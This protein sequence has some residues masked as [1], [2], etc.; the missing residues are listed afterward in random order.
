MHELCGPCSKSCSAVLITTEKKKG[1]YKLKYSVRPRLDHYLTSS[2]TINLSQYCLPGTPG[3]FLF[4]EHSKQP[5]TPGPL[6]SVSHPGSSITHTWDSTILI[7]IRPHRQTDLDH[8]FQDHLPIHK[9]SLR[10]H[11]ATPEHTAVQ[12]CVLCVYVCSLIFP[13]RI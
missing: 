4:L 1:K 9:P 2:A 6:F 13:R 8:S 10:R 11:T 3:P 7:S 5:P 12:Y